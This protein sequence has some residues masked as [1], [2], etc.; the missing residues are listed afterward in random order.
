MTLFYIRAIY[1]QDR[2]F[3]PTKHR[4][5]RVFAAFKEFNIISDAEHDR[6]LGEIDKLKVNSR[7]QP[8]D[9]SVDIRYHINE[10]SGVFPYFEEDV[11]QDRSVVLSISRRPITFYSSHGLTR[12]I[13]ASVEFGGYPNSTEPNGT[14]FMAMY[15]D[16]ILDKL[17]QRLSEILRMPIQMNVVTHDIII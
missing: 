3:V 2:W 16:P 4:L 1:V 14:E 9:Y 12:C 5:R 13:I 8:S 10:G 6:M 7:N 15:K 11:H 17:K